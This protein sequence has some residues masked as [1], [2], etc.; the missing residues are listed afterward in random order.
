MVAQ[1]APAIPALIAGR[2]TRR[3]PRRT[4]LAAPE[5]RIAALAEIGEALLPKPDA[6][7]NP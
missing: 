5:V 2:R 1:L 7:E 3:K 6:G 4:L